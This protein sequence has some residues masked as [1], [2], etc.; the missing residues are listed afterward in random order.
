MRINRSNPDQPVQQPAPQQAAP[1][2]APRPAAKR[3]AP[4]PEPPKPKKEKP[5]KK[6]VRA[7]KG[8]VQYNRKTFHIKKDENL[9]YGRLYDQPVVSIQEALHAVDSATIRGEVF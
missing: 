4:A 3:T 6:P 5:K 8:E 2:P 7:D 1:T 9:L